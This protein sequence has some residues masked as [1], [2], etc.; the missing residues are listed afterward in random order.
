LADAYVEEYRARGLSAQSVGYTRSRLDRWWLKRRRPQIAVEHIDAE[1][2]ELSCESHGVRDAEHDAWLRR[3]SGT[4]EFVNPLWGMKWPKVTPYSRLPK[5]IDYSYLEA[6]WRA[7]QRSATVRTVL[8]TVLAVLYG[9]GLRRG[10]LVLR[11]LD[12]IGRP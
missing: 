9:T 6:M 10:E 1:L 11:R 12:Q 8:I 7:K 3:L 2:L 4:P 5:R